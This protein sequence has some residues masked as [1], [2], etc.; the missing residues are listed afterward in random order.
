MKI[1]KEC[2]IAESDIALR[3]IDLIEE[4]VSSSIFSNSNGEKFKEL[5]IEHD[6]GMYQEIIEKEATGS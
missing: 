3:Y 6:K 5:A 4:E 2:C 1:I